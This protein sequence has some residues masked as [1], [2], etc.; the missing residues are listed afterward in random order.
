M[1][2]EEKFLKGIIVDDDSDA[3]HVQISGAGCTKMEQ[4]AIICS[5]IV[6][7]ADNE[8]DLKTILMS[9]SKYWHFMRGERN[10]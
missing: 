8:I 6:D 3:I 1:A 2:N 9:A 5:M 7:F 4:A 10:E